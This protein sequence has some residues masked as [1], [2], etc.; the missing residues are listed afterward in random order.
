MS[1]SR[2][3]DE[4]QKRLVKMAAGLKGIDATRNCVYTVVAI[5]DILKTCLGPNGM[6]KLIIDRYDNYVISN[7]A[8][9]V[10]RDLDI[11]HPIGEMLVNMGKTHVR[12]QGDGGKIVVLLAAELARRGLKLVD[13]GL[14][15]S[16]IISG[17][18]VACEKAIER[19]NQ[20]GIG[21]NG[22]K[23][24]LRSVASTSLS[25]KFSRRAENHLSDLAV[26]TVTTI[27]EGERPI[28]VKD[29]VQFVKREGGGIVDTELIHGVIISKDIL[30]P[31]MPRRIENAR[32]ALLNEK[33]YLEKPAERSI[34]LL[35]NS[36]ED[37]DGYFEEQRNFG[38]RKFSYIKKSG[39]NVVVTEK[40][41]DKV[42]EQSLAKN[43]IL[44]IRRAK[45]EE[46][47]LLSKACGAKICSK[48]E[49]LNEEHLGY[50]HVVEERRIGRDKYV[51]FSGCKDPKSVAVLVRGG[52]W[53]VCEE[54]ERLLKN[55]MMAVSVAL[56]DRKVV[57]GGGSIELE[58][59]R[60]VRKTSYSVEGKKQLA[61]AEFASAL[62]LIPRI[63]A[64]NAGM[65]EI[66]TL[67]ELRSKHG[68]SQ[69]WLGID[70]E[71]KKVRD[72]VEFGVL[73]P[74]YAKIKSLKSATEFASSIL[75]VDGMYISK[76]GLEKRDQ[77]K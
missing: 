4:V 65:D 45:P 71:N 57:G 69:N 31:K 73:E 50:A 66:N 9:T 70:V 6:R 63:L 52:S 53:Y 36:P 76:M 8:V 43:R 67:M 68:G 55:A 17:Y 46:F 29:K 12:T 74:S 23:T 35:I 10:L 1:K 22:E 75:R 48:V 59:A 20:L 14:H 41:I 56:I 13:E 7:D 27:A 25:G 64:S 15:P 28:D 3:K 18:Y 42:I 40:G 54:V 19:L 62:E 26:E 49:D 16:V 11:Q 37:L 47:K 2:A 32:I 21:V 38:E 24:I 61:V 60:Y 33:L 44:G 72:M 30:S 5:A 77:A 39:A 34:Q 51:L 58:L